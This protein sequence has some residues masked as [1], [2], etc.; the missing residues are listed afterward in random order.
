MGV[1]ARGGAPKLA[2]VALP[3]H[4]LLVE[5]EPVIRELVQTM[6][7]GGEV[8]VSSVADGPSALRA[9]RGEPTPSLVLLDVVLPGL[10]GI[11]V[12]RLLKADPRTTQIPVY[13]LSAR[14]KLVDKEA[15][16]RAGAVGYLEKPFKA[17][18]LF[19]L[20]DRLRAAR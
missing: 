18:D 5:D 3:F 15:A 14:V 2:F 8:T 9:A 19:E 20:V 13:M 16:R 17:A 4:I 12:C 1:T 11:A 10:D 7:T 6:L